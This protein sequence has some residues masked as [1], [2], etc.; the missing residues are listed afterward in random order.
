VL[1]DRF[2]LR[3]RFREDV[4]ARTG[5]LAGPDPRRAAEWREAVE[6]EGASAIICARGGYGSMRILPA[7]DPRP[8]LER[9]KLFMGFSDVTAIHATLN[10]AGLCTVHGPGVAQL[11]QLPA[12][13]L[14]H[15]RALLFGEGSPPSGDA[16]PPPGAGLAGTE[17]LRPGRAT[18][19]LL[20]GNLTLLSHLAGTPYLPSLDG[21]ILFLEDVGEQPYRLDRALTH[22]RLAG[23]LDRVAGVAVGQLTR[24]DDEHGGDVLGL[25]VVREAVRDLGVPAVAGLPAGHEDSN[26]ALPLGARVTLVAPGPGEGGAPRL[27]FDEGATA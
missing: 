17:T 11:A 2:G 14:D 1:R 8:L 20:G 5:Y 19:P 6:D 4:A 25:D 21:A 3:P 9:P 13:P 24:C 26:Y 22:L 15:L 16:P 27:L 7:I 18:G 10:R 23:L 12:E